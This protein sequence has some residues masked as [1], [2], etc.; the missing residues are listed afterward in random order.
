MEFSRQEFWSGVPFSSPGDF[1]NPG[2]ESVPPVSPALVLYRKCHLGS[3]ITLIPKPDKD[4][5]RKRQTNLPREDR[6]K[7][8]LMMSERQQVHAGKAQSP[9]RLMSHI[10]VHSGSIYSSA[11]SK[12]ESESEHSKSQE[13]NQQEMMSRNP[14]CRIWRWMVQWTRSIAADGWNK[15][16]TE[17]GLV[18]I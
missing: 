12:G 3:P 11:N 5:P 18:C 17:N 2:I 1:P 7:N 10:T 16:E 6:C 14:G 4:T 9:S 13:E 15:E 8:S